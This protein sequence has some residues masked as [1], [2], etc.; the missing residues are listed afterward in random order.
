MREPDRHAN[1]LVRVG[2][3]EVD[4]I[5][6]CRQ[7]DR[8]RCSARRLVVDGD[9]AVADTYLRDANRS[10][11]ALPIGLLPLCLDE[12]GD[13]P[14]IARAD[15]RDARLRDAHR[16]DQDARGDEVDDVVPQADVPDQHDGL[17]GVHDA[18][19]IQLH[20]CQQIAVQPADGHV[21][22]QHAGDFAVT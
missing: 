18:D 8:A 10:R 3:C 2:A 14:P 20:A 9:A 7:P 16:V 13:I 6:R 19:V 5:D 4:S 1:R 12:A 17:A 11:G 22:V 21:S 15:E